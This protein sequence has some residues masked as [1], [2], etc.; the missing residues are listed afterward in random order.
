MFH[1]KFT[2]SLELNPRLNSELPGVPC[3]IQTKASHVVLL[4]DCCR[5]AKNLLPSGN[6]QAEL[7]GGQQKVGRRLIDTKNWA[8]TV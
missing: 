1:N 3:H 8:G 6:C 7:A 4:A 5:S 2:L